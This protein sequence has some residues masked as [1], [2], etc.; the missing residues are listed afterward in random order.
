MT[1][2]ISSVYTFLYVAVIIMGGITMTLMLILNI[3]EKDRK[4][5]A[6]FLFVCSIFI[7]MILDFITY[8]FMSEFASGSIVFALITL[9]DTF[10]CI[11]T[12]A[13]VYALIV[14][15]N[16]EKTINV[17]QVCIISAVY[18]VLSQILSIFEGRYDTY[19]LHMEHASGKVILQALN[20]GYVCFIIAVS[21][22]CIYMLMKK[23][24]KSRYRT[25]TLVMALLLVGY[26][27]WIVYWYYST[28]YKSEENLMEIY[29]GD[30]LILMYA[31]FNAAAIYYFY[32]K[33]PLKIRSAQVATDEAVGI[34]S[35]R[36]ELSGREREVLLLLNRGLSNPQIAAELS[37]SENTVKRHVN[38]IFRKTET[39]SRH[40]IIVKV[41]NL[42]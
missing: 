30:P 19:A 23:Y 38:N 42:K 1:F 3:R 29:G 6:V 10:F 34:I 33:D 14:L 20:T 22:R 35:D 17:K 8:Y 2:L 25:L 31:I 36:Y 28:W 16:A 7:F 12:T 37:I 4:H 39:Q 27:L 15:I 18:L 41:S 13:W 5:R 24:Q 9:S 21:I 32:K 26:M 11:L 40:E